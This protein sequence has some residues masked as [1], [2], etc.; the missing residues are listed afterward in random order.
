MARS[1]ILAIDQG[2]TN[3]KA[4]LVGEDGTILARGTTQVR[5]DHPEAGWAEQSADA[6]RDSVAEAIQQAIAACPDAQIVAIAISNQRESVVIWDGETSEPLGP[7]I[8]WQ[9]RRS[10][11]LCARLR[12]GGFE[13]LVR[14]RTGLGLDPLFSSGKLAWLLAR[15]PT[16]RPIKAGTVDSWLI[17]NLTAGTV[18]A[19]DASNAS[20]T[21]LLA[22][23][24]VAWD[25]EILALFGIPKAVLPEV[26]ASDADFGLTKGGFAGLPD[27]IPIKAVMGDS[28]AACFGHGIFEP[29]HVKV[30]IG[31][32]SSLMS[33]TEKRSRST[34]GLSETI[35]WSA[36]GRVLYALE[37]NIT[38]S[39][40]TAAFA[41]EL[42]GIEDPDA[43]TALALTVEDSDG[44]SFVPAL[45]GLGAPHWN[46]EARGVI[47]G[48][49]LRTRP[50]HIA[51]A[52][53]EAIAHQI[54][55]VVEAMDADL[56]TPL[57]SISADG[58]AARNDFLLQMIADFSGKPVQRPAN[59]DLSALGAAMMAWRSAFSR[60]ESNQIL[61]KFQ[62]KLDGKSKSESRNQ[63]RDAVKR[64]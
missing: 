23:D 12:E 11:P 2:T 42:F 58:S 51:R 54:C 7:C 27:G 3:T 31:T 29:G 22:L 17:W 52:S 8:I 49:S 9:C 48:M 60:A 61:S 20:R 39:G 43:L 14:E 5:V 40:H 50:A 16:D 46:D 41:C 6:I 28:H 63:W 55:D 47:C 32:G 35:A 13:P 44:V 26:R 10:A 15:T 37:G 18:H 30:T 25:D 64:A 19:T 53:I 21:Q 45:A 56:D 59:T 4:L 36:E 24:T 38:V 34:H 1:A 33:P 62:P 57:Q